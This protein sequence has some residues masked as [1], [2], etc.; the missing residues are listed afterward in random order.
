M[1]RGHSNVYPQ[2]T[3]LDE[4]S[5]RAMIEMRGGATVY[6]CK[7]LPPLALSRE[8]WVAIGEAMNWIGDPNSDDSYISGALHKE[9]M[10]RAVAFTAFA[11]RKA[12]QS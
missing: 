7:D 1:K 4:V 2:T 3:K 8:E 9:N 12:V 5:G 10:R 11:E 6:S